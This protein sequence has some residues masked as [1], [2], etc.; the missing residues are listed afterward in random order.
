MNRCKTCRARQHR[1]CC[2]CLTL[3]MLG[4][5]K[6]SRLFVVLLWCSVYFLGSIFNRSQ[7]HSSLSRP[8]FLPKLQ[9][10]INKKLCAATSNS[11]RRYHI[12]QPGR[13]GGKVSRL[14]SQTC[15]QSRGKNSLAE[16]TWSLFSSS[17]AGGAESRHV[18]LHQLV[19]Q[20]R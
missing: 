2:V 12:Q 1:G 4:V 8:W 11:L 6:P 15:L 7:T 16:T 13:S 17:S 20:R 10:E 19:L 5:Y 14:V 3:G 9:Q 18:W